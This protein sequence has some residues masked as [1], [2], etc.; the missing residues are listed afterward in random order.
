MAILSNINGKFAVESTGAIQFNGSNGTA[1]YILKSNGNASPTWVAAS[2]VIGGPYLPLSGGILTGATSTSSG[3]S[4]TVGGTLTLQ[5]AGANNTTFDT[6]AQQ[7]II[8]NS[9][10]SSASGLA[11]RSS[12]NTWC[13]QLYASGNGTDY[14]FLASEWGS[15]NMRKNNTGGLYLNDNT[16]YFV[17]PES[18]S[19]MN[20]TIFAGNVTVNGNIIGATGNTTEVGTYSTGAIKRIRMCQGGE[21]HFGDTTTGSA[22]GITEGA[23]DNFGDQDRIGLYCRNELKVYGNSNVLRLTIPTNGTST[24]AGTVTANG[25]LLT[26]NTG[27]V[28]S[29]ATG[30]GLTGG[31]ITTSGTLSLD[32]PNSAL[33]A[34]L[35]TY[36]TT[37]SGAR[38]RCTAP[39]NTNSG[40]MFSIEITIYSSYVQHNYVVSAYMYS[41]TNQWYDTKAIY[42]TTA[43]AT[44]DIYVGRDANGKA[45]ISIANGSYTGVLVHN[46]TQG[47]VTSVADTYDP[48]TITLDNGNENSASVTTTQIWTS[49]NHTPGDYLPLA[50][51]TM[52]GAINMNSNTITNGGDIYSNSWFR[53]NN[54]SQGFYNQATGN[55]FYSDGAYW[56]VGYSGTTGIRLRNGHAG[57]IMGYLYGETSGQFGLLDKDG[58]WTLR[59]DGASVTELRCNDVTGFQMAA[60]GDVTLAGNVGIGGAADANYRLL[61]SETTYT[62]G[63]SV[64]NFINGYSGSRVTYDT[65]LICQT[66]VPCLSIIER[67]DGNQANEQKLTLAVGDHKAVIRTAGTSSGMYFNVAAAVTAP[68]YQSTSGI[69]ALHIANNGNIT[70]NSSST[71]FNIDADSVLAINNAGTNAVGIYAASGDT[72]YLGGNNTW[73]MY[74]T[75]N[76]YCYSRSWINIGAAAGIYSSTNGAHWYPNANS[77]YGG[78]AAQGVRNGY[79]GITFYGMGGTGDAAQHLMGD[80]AGNIGIWSS[81]NS[82]GWP[83]YYNRSHNCV[84]IGSSTTSSSY[85]LQANGSAHITGGLYTAGN[86]QAGISGTGD[87]YIGGLSSNYFRFHTNNSDTYFDM[88][89]GN[90]YWRQ[91]ASTRYYFYTTTANM[92][93]N[94][95]LTQNS[96]ERVKENIVEISDCI[97]KVKAIRGVYYNRTDFNTE[98]KKVGVIA[99]EVEKVLPEVILEAPD[100]GFK[101]VAYA[102]LTSILVNAIKEQQ[103][104]ID[105]LKTRIENLEK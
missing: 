35:A 95:S 40:K 64:A 1:G 82:S 15:W 73:Q 51:G 34:V 25:V 60:S 101:S 30:S 36:G 77:T 89:C 29:V 59:T 66:D 22:L 84:G 78:W 10:Y 27:T 18:T 42:T 62:S 2:T 8:K 105:D 16:T 104:I 102:E 37:G 55:H 100:T 44:P 72:I 31:T 91:G 74:F 50:G 85:V 6:S 28:T 46:M 97:D 9:A 58:N 83:F 96:D 24:F 68:G 19:N 33:G 3:I 75:T 23:W 92:T 41:T 76:N 4:F 26:G 52:T 11:L 98:V 57:T 12:N 21:I 90:L 53:N 80:A 14:G 65:V 49:R 13:M 103:V 39:F 54:S 63:H 32:R 69:N 94:G 47:Y 45:Y 67:Y 87:I 17:Q 70:L 20:A 86:V 79:Y 56:N 93:I 88:N 38:I 7:L 71:V 5:G 61:V 81:S 43:S 48:W 99:Q